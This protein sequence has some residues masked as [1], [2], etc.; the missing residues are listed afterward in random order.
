M[1]DLNKLT[2]KDIGRGVI[3]TNPSTGEQ[4][5]GR[6]KSFTKEGLGRI[7]VVYKC[8]GNWDRYQDYIGVQTGCM[9][10]KFKEE[11]RIIPEGI[12]KEEVLYGGREYEGGND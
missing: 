2:K 12:S 1:I 3:Y 7:F 8:A 6:L 4:E 9:N 10:L 11:I 5:K